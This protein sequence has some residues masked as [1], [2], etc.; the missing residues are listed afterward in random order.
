[1]KYRRDLLKAIENVASV[2][3]LPTVM[4]RITMLL[5]N[6][7]TSAEEIGRAITTDQSLASKV[8]KLVNSAFYGFPGRIS[9]ITHA[10]VILGF[11]TIK[12][13]VL[14][15]TIIDV[16][17]KRQ[18]GIAGF[19]MEQFWFHSVACGAAAKSLAKL[20]GC[21]ERE[22]CFIAGLL[23]DIGKIIICQY[24]PDE[25]EQ[26]VTNAQKKH[27][28][29]LESEGQ[30]FRT[31]H[32]EIGGFLTESWNLPQNLQYPVNFHHQPQPGDKYYT[33]TAIVHIADILVRAMDYGNSGDQKI[34]KASHR[35]WEDLG[36]NHLSLQQVLE[37][38]NDEVEK[39][40]V[41][42]QI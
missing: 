11:A 34:P 4:E 22:E 38:V 42:M 7:Q 16:F 10:V 6:P 26:I 31:S 20:V 21:N 2:P 18:A 19:D 29:F 9:T 32:Q 14:T 27:I 15:A 37:S 30:L 12:N 40:T 24:L 5:Q 36:L 17:R 28:L 25:F 3:T 8:L 13:I 39:A 41:F 23:H 33:I 1:M 35:V